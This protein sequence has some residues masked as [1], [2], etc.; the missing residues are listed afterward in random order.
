MLSTI[1]TTTISAKTTTTTF[2]RRSIHYVLV[3][4]L[5]YLLVT[6]T[7]TNARTRRCWKRKYTV[8]VAMEGTFMKACRRNVTLHKCEGYCKSEA[9]PVVFDDQVRWDVNCQCCQPDSYKNITIRFPECGAS[10]IIKDI[11]NCKCKPC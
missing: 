7:V 2:I 3:V 5:L 8:E 9:G 11:S 10:K 6:P 1:S 4:G